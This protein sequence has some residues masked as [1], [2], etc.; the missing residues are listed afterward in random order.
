MKKKSM[1]A[2][3]F[4]DEDYRDLSDIYGYKGFHKTKALAKK[5]RR[6]IYVDYPGEGSP[7]IVK[8]TFEVSNG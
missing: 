6:E 5:E 7:V 4:A 1:Y 3:M 2:V 8:I